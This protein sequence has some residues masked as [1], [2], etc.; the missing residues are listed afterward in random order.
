MC[1]RGHVS[2]H[3]GGP[4][5]VADVVGVVFP[6]GVKVY[7][8]DPAG[9][10]LSRGDR[11]VVQTSSGPEIGQVV[12]PPHEIDDALIFVL[13]SIVRYSASLNVGHL[14]INL[15]DVSRIIL[16]IIAMLLVLLTLRAPNSVCGFI[17]EVTAGALTYVAACFA[18]EV[19]G[20]RTLLRVAAG[21]LTSRWGRPS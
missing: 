7:H 2:H 18:L 13:A 17:A 9:L 21:R 14:W 20:G 6:G 10:E 5:L 19:A 4:D 11:V 16:A 12:E 8:F 15:R 3:Q 1:Y